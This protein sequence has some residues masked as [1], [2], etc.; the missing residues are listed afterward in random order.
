VEIL[1]IPFSK[2]KTSGQQKRLR[3]GHE[4]SDDIHRRSDDTRRR[5]F[6]MQ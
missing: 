5:D 4:E 3:P 1:L 2:S 6:K